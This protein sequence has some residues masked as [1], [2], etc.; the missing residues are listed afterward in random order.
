[1]TSSVYFNVFFYKFLRLSLG[2]SQFP[3]TFGCFGVLDVS[4]EV[5]MFAIQEKLKDFA[6]LLDFYS[7]NYNPRK[8]RSINLFFKS[9]T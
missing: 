1:M 9:L 7:D 6:I 2:S 4:I 3:F 5:L 8:S